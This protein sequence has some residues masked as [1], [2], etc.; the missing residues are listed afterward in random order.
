MNVENIDK[1]V[2]RKYVEMRG[3]ITKRVDRIVGVMHLLNLLRH[4]GD[5]EIEVSPMALA[6][7]AD[8]V[9]GDVVS[10]QEMLD[11][12]IYLVDAEGVLDRGS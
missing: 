4:C 1:E 3:E 12:F 2:L 9:D 6:V 7:V 8:L 5:D 11:G 10:I